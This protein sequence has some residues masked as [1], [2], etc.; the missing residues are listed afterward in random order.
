VT[1]EY[2]LA[3]QHLGFTWPELTDIALMSFDAAFL[4]WDEKQAMIAVVKAEIERLEAEY[5]KS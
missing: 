4:P 1:D 3:H 5:Q 2:W